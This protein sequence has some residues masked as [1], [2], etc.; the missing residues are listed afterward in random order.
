[1]DQQ[2]K[3]CSDDP[4]CGSAIRCGDGIHRCP[5]HAAEAGFCGVCGIESQT[6]VC[7]DCASLNEG[8]DFDLGLDYED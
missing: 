2:I 4:G 5:I 3:K 7:P 1:M 6:G 8:D